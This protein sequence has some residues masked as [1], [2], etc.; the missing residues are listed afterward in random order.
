[1]GT[2]KST[3]A[4]YD[5]TPHAMSY[6]FIA[7]DASAATVLGPANL[8]RAPA[9]T[10]ASTP[11]WINNS[12]FSGA[13]TVGQATTLRFGNMVSCSFNVTGVTA[14]SGT[15]TATI[16]V[17]HAL[18]GGTF[19]TQT[20][21]GAVA[22]TNTAAGTLLTG[23]AAPLVG[24]NAFVVTM[25]NSTGSPLALNGGIQVILQYSLV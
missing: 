25:V 6:P 15:N 16:P 9:D 18:Y 2:A 14:A 5:G 13:P 7:Q 19:S 3:T 4:V 1:M 24:S 22:A 8:G 20:G 17:P 10:G 21:S 11:S 12:G 23:T